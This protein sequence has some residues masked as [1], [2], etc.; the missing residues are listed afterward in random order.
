MPS[1]DPFVMAEVPGRRRVLIVAASHGYLTLWI[2]PTSP[3]GDE[4]ST[5]AERP[6]LCGL[7]AGADQIV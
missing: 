1:V 6:R 3:K 5:P 2:L 7:L 4:V